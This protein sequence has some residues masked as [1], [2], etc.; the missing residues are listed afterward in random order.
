MTLDKQDH[1]TDSEIV[2]K[3]CLNPIK[4]NAKV[5]HYCSRD[6]NFWYH[7]G[8]VIAKGFTV[9]GIVAT[10]YTLY[11]A[12]QER[13]DASLAL[14]RATSAL[15]RADSVAKVAEHRTKELRK[16]QSI[17]LKK[18]DIVHLGILRRNN[19]IPTKDGSVYNFLFTSPHIWLEKNQRYTGFGQ[20]RNYLPILIGLLEHKEL[21]PQ[22]NKNNIELLSIDFAEMLVFMWLCDNY[23]LGWQRKHGVGSTLNA[24]KRP[25]GMWDYPQASPRTY[26]SKDQ[27]LQQ[28]S[29][30]FFTPLLHPETRDFH[31][32]GISVPVGTTLTTERKDK[33]SH[34]RKLLFS[35]EAFSLNILLYSMGTS[36]IGINSFS[37]QHLD[38]LL[39][40]KGE[41]FLQN[42]VVLLQVDFKPTF[43]LTEDAAYIYQWLNGMVDQFHKDFD[44]YAVA[45]ALLSIGPYAKINA[46]DKSF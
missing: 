44:W 26:I 38:E 32:R 40:L 16:M 15:V 39:D 7:W 41:W 9:A 22:I 14:E 17:I 43:A 34:R 28:L 20:Y 23:S 5:C 46:R 35:N 6:Q 31:F 3:Y 29:M 30:N 36:P 8:G 45:D 42:I 24:F 10:L 21:W 12:Q 25:Y 27:L 18:Q 11:V 19:P 13:F 1:Y 2:C 37:K 4:E 33:P